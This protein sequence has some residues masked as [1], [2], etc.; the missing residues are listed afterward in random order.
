MALELPPVVRI[1]PASACNLR[2]RHCPTG[3]A[4]MARGIMSPETFDRVLDE[5]GRHMPPFRVAVLYHGGE[6]LLN[7]A[8]PSMARRLKDVGMPFVKTVS[9]GMRLA[10]QLIDPIIDSGLDVMEF[11]IDGLSPDENDA[12]RDRAEFSRII[13]NVLRLAVRVEERGSALR[14]EVATTQFVRFGQE[15][16]DAKPPVP[17]FIVDAF[18]GLPVQ[19][20]P[21]WAVEWP[22]GEHDKERF[23][24]RWD[25]PPEVSPSSCSL[26]DDTFTIRA[27]GDVV[28]CCYDLTSHT[29]LGNIMSSTIEEIWSGEPFAEF[30]TRFSSRDYPS[31]CAGCAYVTGPRYLIP[32]QNLLPVV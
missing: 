32:R 7:P 9:N 11:S 14:I 15:E 6:P 28:P 19:F 31:L 23:T 29:V 30:R 17:Q 16:V 25:G 20:K 22:S 2:C 26:L 3:V 1:E 8:F 27:N 10:P 24:V 18:A 4:D 5:V 21:T 13:D 12:I